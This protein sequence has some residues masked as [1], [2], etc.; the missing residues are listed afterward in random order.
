MRTAFLGIPSGD[1]TWEV[2]LS[3]SVGAIGA[4]VAVL[5]AFALQS[6]HA[7]RVALRQAVIAY[8]GELLRQLERWWVEEE[9][10]VDDEEG[11]DDEEDVVDVAEMAASLRDSFNLS[12]AHT[13]VITLARHYDRRLAAE[14]AGVSDDL[15]K[16]VAVRND[17]ILSEVEGYL[18]VW[19]TDHRRWR[20]RREPFEV[21]VRR[22][23]RVEEAQAEDWKREVD[24]AMRWAADREREERRSRIADIVTWLRDP[25]NR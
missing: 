12:R 8:R 20:L 11:V 15:F 3:G 17:D 16:G 13:D 6:R 10:D 1:I 24:A 7:G 14:L 9:L 19:L 23:E 5:V 22:N 2:L 4:V 18:L 21:I 25:D